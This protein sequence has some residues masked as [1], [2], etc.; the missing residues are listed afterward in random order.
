MQIGEWPEL[1]RRATML[2]EPGFDYVWVADHFTGIPGQP[3]FE[4][5]STLAAF[6]A[7]VERACEQSD[8]LTVGC[9]AAGRDP[10]SVRRCVLAWR[11]GFDPLDSAEEFERFVD[12]YAAAGFDEFNVGWLA[13][14]AGATDSVLER[15]AAD[16]LP[17]LGRRSDRYRRT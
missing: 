15:I 9:L 17:R 5:W 16:V 2:E 10:G 8:R 1:R 6:E 3:W 14:T 4:G 11:L 13:P 12:A 7:G